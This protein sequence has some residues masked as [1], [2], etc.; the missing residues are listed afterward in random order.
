MSFRINELIDEL[1]L[2]EEN[3]DYN[4]GEGR[5]DYIKRLRRKIRDLSLSEFIW[6]KDEYIGNIDIYENIKLDDM[7]K[8]YKFLLFKKRLS[9]VSHIYTTDCQC[10]CSFG[11]PF[12]FGTIFI[13]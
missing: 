11:N 9:F 13:F 12:F 5:E 3:P 2:H 1:K 8:Y 6:D 10:V 4:K 7:K